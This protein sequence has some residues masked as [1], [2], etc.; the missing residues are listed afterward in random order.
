MC[1]LLPWRFVCWF[2]A[3]LGVVFFIALLCWYPPADISALGALILKSAGIT[4]FTL[5]TIIKW[6]LWRWVW[7]IKPSYFN[8]AFF[9]DLQGCYRGTLVSDFTTPA[10]RIDNVEL[11]IRQ[12]LA[13]I[14]VRLK[15]ADSESTTEIAQ[16]VPVDK[17]E[18]HYRLF[19]IYRNEPRN[20]VR[21]DSLPHI[22]GAEL[23]IQLGKRL[24]L[25]GRYFNDPPRATSG[26]M[27]FTRYTVNITS[28]A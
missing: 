6:D 16:I 17:E 1:N 15:T 26:E 27:D 28:G 12:R 9:P 2:A 20:G 19:Y 21:P 24:R 23:T 13:K 25:Y 3:I 5:M 7:R 18:G 8:R 11:T 4:T 10:T 14:T 22:G